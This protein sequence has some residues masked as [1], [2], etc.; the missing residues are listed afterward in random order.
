M[1]TPHKNKPSLNSNGNKLS[2]CET[3]DTFQSAIGPQ[4]F[5]ASIEFATQSAAAILIC[6]TMGGG[7]GGH[8]LNQST[9]QDERFT[10]VGIGKL[11]V[12]IE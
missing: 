9:V 7:E 11:T 8:K 10:Y 5:V 3:R 2:N 4:I 6:K 1:I 12:A